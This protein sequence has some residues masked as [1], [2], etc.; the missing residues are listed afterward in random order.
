MKYPLALINLM[1]MVWAL[2]CLLLFDSS[3]LA[4]VVYT[5]CA[6]INFGVG[7]WCLTWKE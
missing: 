2:Q 6:T 5:T 4:K 3:L 7:L 1:A